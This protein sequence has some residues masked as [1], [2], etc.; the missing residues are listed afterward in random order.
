MINR[1][2]VTTDGSEQAKKAVEFS[3]DIAS[4]YNATVCLVHAIKEDQIST[5]VKGFM[6]SEHLEEKPKRVYLEQVGGRIIK[7]AKN[8]L[9]EHG[10]KKTAFAIFVGNPA[11]EI[12]KFVKAN[13]IDMIVFGYNGVGTLKEFGNRK[14][15]RKVT[16]SANCPCITVN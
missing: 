8:D 3:A 11:Q 14:I 2:M 15:A 6:E 5:E 10:V 13:K 7:E 9:Y 16:R 1:I 12:I 4:K